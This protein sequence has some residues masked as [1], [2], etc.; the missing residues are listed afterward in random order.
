MAPISGFADK[1]NIWHCVKGEGKRQKSVSFFFQAPLNEVV[2]KQ[3]H[4][5]T[6]CL[7]ILSGRFEISCV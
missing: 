5:I 4:D 6:N 7:P 1:E 2:S 3:K